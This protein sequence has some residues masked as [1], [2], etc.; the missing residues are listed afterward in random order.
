MKLQDCIKIL[1]Q[2]ITSLRDSE[3][4]K[5]IQIVRLENEL[6]DG[7]RQKNQLDN[8]IKA[9]N[10]NIQEMKTE[11]GKTN[12]KKKIYAAANPTDGGETDDG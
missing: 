11:L 8:T 9:L 4:Q 6:K 3:G 10:A 12:P 1:K 2:Q 5:E 7:Q